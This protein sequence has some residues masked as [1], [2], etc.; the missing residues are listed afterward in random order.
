MSELST[1]A[2]EST[3]SPVTSNEPFQ[4]RPIGGRI[5]AEVRGVTL[6]ADLDDNAIAAINNA[7]LEHKV[8]FFRGQSHLDDAAQEAFAARFGETV[9]HPTVPSLSSGSRLLELDSK[10]G[11]RANSWHTDVTFVDAYPKISILRGVVIPPA[12]GDTVW[13]NTAAAYANLPEA[14][15]DL[16][17]KLWALHSN[18]YDYAATRN[19]PDTESERE[20]RKQFTS[21]LYETEHPVVRVHPE[22][23]ERTL[24]LGH[25]VQRFIGLSQRDSDRLAE[26]FHD[27]VTRL[28]NTVRWRWT[29]GD[30]AIWD[31][32][33]TQHYAVADYADAHRVVRRATVHGDVPVGIDGRKSRIVKQETRTA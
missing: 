23:G 1:L 10:H 2:A 15:R 19:V 26:I 17:D 6:S 25:F 20:Y 5:G 8:L 24:V 14:L 11:T 21:T 13:A 3:L 18:A 30:V 12:G 33:A 31:N 27:H 7:L 16:A 32:R 29:Q 28:E 4:V 22:T 9:A